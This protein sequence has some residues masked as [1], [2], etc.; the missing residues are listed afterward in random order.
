[1]NLVTKLVSMGAVAASGFVASKVAA[2]SWTRVT[3]SEP[4][5]DD[6]GTGEVL[7]IVAFAAVSAVLAALVQHYVAK[8]TSSLMTKARLDKEAAESK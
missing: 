5:T 8:G 7:Q 2:S 4:P 6:D 1:M 3:G